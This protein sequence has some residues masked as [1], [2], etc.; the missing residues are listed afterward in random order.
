VL[1]AAAALVGPLV[2]GGAPQTQLKESF[3]QEMLQLINR[4]RVAHGLRPVALDPSLNSFVDEY[5]A[6]QIRNRT[7][8]H[9]T[10]DG[11]PPYLRYSL[12][13]GTDGV[14]E[15]A[16]A[17]S[18]NY[19]FPNSSILDMIRKSQSSMLSERPPHDGHRRTLLDPDATHVALGLAWEGGEFRLVQEFLRRYVTLTRPVPRTAR[20]DDRV[21]IEGRPLNSS[22]RVE[23]VS[24][25]HEDFPEPMSRELANAIDTYGLPKTR[26]DFY[27]EKAKEAR[28]SSARGSLA[29]AAERSDAVKVA[30]D[31]SFSFAT[32]FKDGPGLYTVV[33]WV[34][35]NGKSVSASNISIEVTGGRQASY[36][37]L[38]TR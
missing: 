7:T 25:H 13:G 27:V 12:A 24:L 21:V 31:G 19:R 6:R 32:P 1:A 5:C 8:G 16:A 17:W 35:Q 11:Q 3:R 28:S 34:S 22:I 33:I 10:L 15:N 29:R 9:F 30:E 18:A 4:D 20:T 37:P 23:A 36:P 26:R 14:S 38:G 2:G